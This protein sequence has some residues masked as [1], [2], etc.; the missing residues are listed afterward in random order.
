MVC[1]VIPDSHISL[2]HMHC[3]TI[4]LFAS[5]LVTV[6][7]AGD[8]TLKMSAGT[9]HSVPLQRISIHRSLRKRGEQMSEGDHQRSYRT[10][11]KLLGL[12]P[13]DPTK[14]RETV[15]DLCRSSEAI[16]K[17]ILPLQGLKLDFY[18]T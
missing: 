14:F 12:S 2:G 6:K 7:I 9:G 5:A 13:P 1:E 15:R 11:L 4:C 8:G 10:F 16:E 17:K 18:N 3:K